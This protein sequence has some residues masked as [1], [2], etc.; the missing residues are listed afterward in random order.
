M[1]TWSDSP[2]YNKSTILYDTQIIHMLNHQRPRRDDL[3]SL[4]VD[5]IRT[6]PLNAGFLEMEAQASQ[7]FP[8]F[9][10]P[11]DAPDEMLSKSQNPREAT[12][13]VPYHWVCSWSPWFLTREVEHCP[14]PGGLLHCLQS[15]VTFTYTTNHYLHHRAL[16]HSGS[17]L[18]RLDTR[19]RGNQ[20]APYNVNQSQPEPW[21]L[22]A[23]RSWTHPPPDTNKATQTQDGRQTCAQNAGNC[24][25]AGP[26]RYTSREPL[27]HTTYINSFLFISNIIRNISS[28]FHHSLPIPVVHN[29]RLR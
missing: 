3:M 10:P 22:T 28:Q 16:P 25:A 15:L 2:P 29:P 26:Q 21:N 13:Y 1:N 19:S 11:G 7:I 17:L 20:T 5:Y 4:Q 27:H 23:M 24:S 14:N 8:E 18:R 6:I 12:T 9:L